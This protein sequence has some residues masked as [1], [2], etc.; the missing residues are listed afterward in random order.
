MGIVITCLF[1]HEE[2]AQLR[3]FQAFLGE[4]TH[5]WKLQSNHHIA[6]PPEDATSMAMADGNI[7][8]DVVHSTQ[9]SN[10]LVTK[11]VH[12]LKIKMWAKK[13]ELQGGMGTK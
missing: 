3:I 2:K 5:F 10:H 13:G 11:S 7:P 12:F 8:P 9:H 4:E 6:K 1:Q